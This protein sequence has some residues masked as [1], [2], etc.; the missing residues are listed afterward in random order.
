MTNSQS[1]LYLS[2]NVQLLLTVFL[3][4]TLWTLY[5]RLRQTVFFRW[6]AWAWTSFVVYLVAATVSLAVGSA[7][8]PV[9]T[10]C[11]VLLLFGGLYEA[12]FLIFGGWSWLNPR[13]PSGIWLRLG[14]FAPLLLTALSVSYGYVWRAEPATSMAFRNFPRAFALAVA[15]YFCAFVF[16]RQAIR[17]RSWAAGITGFF[18]LT[19]AAD[20]TLYASS[21][22]EFLS[23]RFGVF[24][25][26]EVQRLASAESMLQPWLL[27]SDLISTGGICL[28]MILLL[29]ETYQVTE[30][31]LLAT[32]QQTVG[33]SEY[34]AALQAEILERHRV[35][36]ALRESEDRYRDL[37]EHSEDIIGTHDLQGRILSINP[38]AARRL[39]YRIDELLDMRLQD[40]LA[41]R[42]RFRFPDFIGRLVEHG[43]AHGRMIVM[44]RT[45]EERIWEYTSTLRTAGVAAPIVRGMAQD[46]T[47]RVRAEESVLASQAK[48][49]TAFRSNPSA[50]TITS[51]RDGRFIDVNTSFE[52]QSGFSREEA[53]GRTA[54][55]LGI[56]A[57]E[58]DLPDILADTLS[59]GHV[60]SREVRLRTKSGEIRT[61]LY[62]V[63]VIQVGGD[64][65]ALAAG[66]DITDR[67]KM[68]NALRESET[69]FRS[70]TDHASCAIWV[71]QDAKLVYFNREVE[72]LT[73]YSREELLAMQPW[74][75]VDPEFRPAMQNR[76][77][78]RPS[79]ERTF[80]H[81]QY[82]I[83]TKTGEE[84]WLQLS[85]T[86]LEYDGRP[87]I[88]ATVFDITPTK[89]AERELRE[90]ALFMEGL[91]SNS[92]FGIVI[93]DQNHRVRFCNPAFERMFQFTQAELEGRDL[94]E[95]IAPH[96]LEE[97][98]RLTRSVK[99]GGVVHATA[100]RRRKDGSL[101]DVELHGVQLFAGEKFIGAFAFY[102]D[103]SERKRSQEKLLALRS[104]LTRAQEEER[105]R[106]ARDLH[107]DT[108]QRL[109]L[110][111]I[112]L[113]QLKQTSLDA[114]SALAPQLD[115]LLRIAS[116]IT[117]D[118]HNVSRRLHPSQ[119]ELLGLVPALNNFFKD[120]ASRN[121]MHIH[122]IHSGVRCKPPHDVA[123]CLYRV[124]QEA[125][126]NVQ[127]HSGAP[128]ADVELSEESGTIRLRVT[129]QGAGFDPGA[130]DSSQGLGLLSM[131][132]RLRSMGGELL[133]LS[134]PG[135]GTCVDA[136]IPITPSVRA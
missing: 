4:I 85:D 39:G 122:F 132:E 54:Q 40:I 118:V 120:F 31:D 46:I 22:Y 68:E 95:L 70:L 76:A 2:I 7:W 44:S 20:Q 6:W 10:L 56:W 33:L 96:D 23:H 29:I 115:S 69:R 30:R 71:L 106:I 82:K 13:R 90:H 124:A 11:I 47:D 80:T 19:Y 9:K 57:E 126:R 26:S 112:D 14:L 92:P 72:R 35:E 130:L 78:P 58:T 87:A 89:R 97:A 27:Y 129:D 65:W 34:N 75:L 67:I 125:V 105:A 24:F 45:G 17:S 53:I 123:L 1:T 136:S 100:Q 73:G 36:Q 77:L 128:R 86:V 81:F 109:A 5:T 60:P 107:D 111:S 37:V 99:S 127:K 21:F 15:L 116:E 64:L 98:D 117:S 43:H 135:G 3:V 38:A 101:L 61:A 103:I 104:R 55:E 32:R 50:M 91:I 25:P 131:E 41:P 94:D 121:A 63:E 52:K 48:F 93:K 133:I 110:L 88:L 83:R 74:D 84:R 113:E 28:G 114:N 51:L 62:S 102:Q 79:P 119:V 49:A 59:R 42:A 66:E 108:G 134:T 8:S 16:L 12:V 18:C